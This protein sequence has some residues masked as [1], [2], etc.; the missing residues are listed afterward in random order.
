MF[1]LC[2]LLVFRYSMTFLPQRRTYLNVGLSM[3]IISIWWAG[4]S[5]SDFSHCLSARSYPMTFWKH[6]FAEIYWKFATCF[7]LVLAMWEWYGYSTELNEKMPFS[8]AEK[9]KIVL[10]LDVRRDATM[11]DKIYL[12]T[13]KLSLS[14]QTI[15]TKMI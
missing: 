3:S 15:H 11:C 7:L 5:K 9:W 4:V 10:I 12:V 8:T 2:N 1:V 6:V 14:F 13:R